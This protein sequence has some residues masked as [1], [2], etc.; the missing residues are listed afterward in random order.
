MQVKQEMIAVETGSRVQN[1]DCEDPT[2]ELKRPG[3]PY[4]P[5]PP[6]AENGE[7]TSQAET[8]RIPNRTHDLCSEHAPRSFAEYRISQL[9]D[10]EAGNGR[11]RGTQ[12][13]ERP[14]SAP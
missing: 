10:C 7:N 8:Y 11:E 3:V 1:G 13:R 6:E 12:S 2:A 14:R 4:R 9:P 5:P